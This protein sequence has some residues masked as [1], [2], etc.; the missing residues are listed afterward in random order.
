MRYYSWQREGLGHS[1]P[2]APALWFYL[3]SHRGVDRWLCVGWP[4]GCGDVISLNLVE[5]GGHAGPLPG[6]L[7]E[8]C[9]L[10]L[11]CGM[12]FGVAIASQSSEEM[13][14]TPGASG[15][16]PRARRGFLWKGCGPG[17]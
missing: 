15:K 8:G 11:P 4:C 17:R 12:D 16:F 3:E 9:L 13:C 14:A 5:G 6:M 2:D 10:L 7:M 1:D